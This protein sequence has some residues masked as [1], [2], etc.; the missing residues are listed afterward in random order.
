MTIKLTPTDELKMASDYL[1]GRGRDK[2]R[3]EIQ[4]KIPRQERQMS[5]EMQD[6]IRET[7]LRSLHSQA[8][9][10][11]RLRAQRDGGI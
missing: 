7:F 2:L 4:T 5:Q 10:W 11:D 1:V 9:M 8:P 3:N 6:I